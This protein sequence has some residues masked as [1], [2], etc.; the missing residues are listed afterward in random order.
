MRKFGAPNF[1]VF[2]MFHLQHRWTASGEI[3]MLWLHIVCHWATIWSYRPSLISA[4]HQIETELFS[5][6]KKTGVLS[7]ETVMTCMVWNWRVQ[8]SKQNDLNFRRFTVC[9]MFN[10]LQGR[11]DI[12]ISF[13][14]VVLMCDAPCIF[15]YD[16]S[17]FTNICTIISLLYIPYLHVSTYSVIIREFKIYK[18]F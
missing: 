12:L 17:Y 18:R 9:W 15:V 13:P 2:R 10:Q 4:L 6:C 8:I 1:V 16:C 11:V 14:T 3:W 7:Y 5:I